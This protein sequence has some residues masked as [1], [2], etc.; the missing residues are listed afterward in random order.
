M[1]CLIAGICGNGPNL[2]ILPS[3]MMVS[4]CNTPAHAARLLALQ[5]GASNPENNL[6]A[7][8]LK[9][10]ANKAFERGN[11]V[12]AEGLYTEV[13]HSL[14]IRIQICTSISLHDRVRGLLRNMYNHEA[15]I[16]SSQTWNMFCSKLSCCWYDSI[17]S[18]GHRT[19]SIRRSSLYLCQQ[20]SF[21]FFI[22]I[23]FSTFGTIDFLILK[24]FVKEQWSS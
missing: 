5:C 9:Q 17:T 8:H 18:A 3:E 16:P 2:V 22:S 20:V 21:S 14:S 19:Q 6:Q 24:M 4:H 7:L 23:Y 1:C 10:Q 12:E 15:R 11:L 13:C